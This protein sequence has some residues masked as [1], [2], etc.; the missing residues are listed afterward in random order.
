MKKFLLTAVLLSSMGLAAIAAPAEIFTV[1]FG[2]KG[3]VSAPKNQVYTATQT[4]TGNDNTAVANKTWTVVNFNNNNNGWSDMIK[5]GRKNTAST[6]SVATDFAF[7]E[8]ITNIEVTVKINSNNVTSANLYISTDGSTWG[9]AIASNTSITT[10]TNSISFD[11]PAA[12]AAGNL[13]YKVDFVCTSAKSNGVVWLKSIKYTGEASNPDDTR[14]EAGLEFA[15]TS[16]DVVLGDAFEA[17]VVTNPNNLSPITYTSSAP[18]VATVDETTGA[19]TIV[20]AGTTTITAAYAVEDNANFKPGSAQYKINVL[21]AAT[22]IAEFAAFGEGKEVIMNC[23]LTVTYANGQ[24]V[25][26]TDGTSYT[27]V[28][29]TNSLATGDIIAK[30]WKGTNEPFNG[31]PEIKPVSGTVFETAGTAEVTYA[32]VDAYTEANIN[33]VLVL[34]NVVFAAATPAAKTNFTGKVGE[35]EYTFRNNFTLASVAA[36]TYDV[37]LAVA[38]YNSTLQ[39]YPI[40]YIEVAAPE[41]VGDPQF[42]NVGISLDGIISGKLVFEVMNYSGE[43]PKVNVTVLDAA[44][45][46]L[47]ADQAFVDA[48]LDEPAAAP[49]RAA[50]EVEIFAYNLSGHIHQPGGKDTNYSLRADIKVGNTLTTTVDSPNTPTGVEGIVVEDA[51]APA[52]YFNLQG[53]RVANPTNGLY[54]RRQGSTVSKVYVH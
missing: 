5:C 34:K 52:E 3:N 37:K 45:N 44:G 16:Y 22:S 2:S 23:P 28:Y 25:Y 33:Q 47:T 7:S 54:I 17:P 15:T 12:S 35:T 21:A 39:A 50:G 26:V 36:G 1:S 51:N 46:V 4:Y 29:G 43:T 6:G 24:N 13:Y 18:E 40:E 10:S 38:T 30:G 41:F 9:N 11:V 49:A 42:V 48:T 20:G 53:V 31:L 19:V 14:A 8:K 32:E 27:L